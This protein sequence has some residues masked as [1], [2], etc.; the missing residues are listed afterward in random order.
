MK[1]QKIFK[2]KALEESDEILD[3]REKVWNFRIR[4][5]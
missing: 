4:N 1:I 5:L 3:I 2:L